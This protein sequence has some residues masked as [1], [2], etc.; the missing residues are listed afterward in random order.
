[1]FTYRFKRQLRAAVLAMSLLPAGSAL[2]AISLD[3][4]LGVDYGDGRFDYLTYGSTGTAFVSPLLYLGALDAL[5]FGVTKPPTEQESPDLGYSVSHSAFGASTLDISYAITNTTV[6]STFSDLRFMI[7]AQV[8]GS[9]T[10]MDSV[11]EVWS[12]QIAG[13][14]D[15]RQIAEYDGLNPL[16]NQIRTGNGVTEGPNPCLVACDAD[17][18][19]Q[20]NRATLSPGET[21]SIN[22]RLVDDP[23]LVLSGR[24]LMATSLDTAG[25]QLVIGNPQ[26]VPEP[27]TYLLLAAGLLMVAVATQ[28]RFG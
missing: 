25:T 24:Y 17:L 26:L 3:P 8:D 19:L 23:A 18:A 7:N 14:P 6:A 10:F 27:Q 21:W 13:D 28:R 22:L 5:P 16:L 2:A 4:G 15:R 12:A 11:S 9:S 1:M 20:W